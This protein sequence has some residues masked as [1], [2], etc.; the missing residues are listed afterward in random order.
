VIFFPSAS[1]HPA[2]APASV[3]GVY[4]AGALTQGSIQ[5]SYISAEKLY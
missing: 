5:Q 4:F 1:G 3:A 2:N